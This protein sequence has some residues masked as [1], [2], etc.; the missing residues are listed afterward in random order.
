VEKCE[1]KAGKTTN[2]R[3]RGNGD[4]KKYWRGREIIRCLYPK[5]GG[6]SY[7]CS[8]NAAKPKGKGGAGEEIFISKGAATD[9]LKK[10]EV[11][12]KKSKK[13]YDRRNT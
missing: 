10:E 9:P 7:F 12:M 3:P 8:K 11:R 2:K 13:V 4:L 5:S 6:R 1:Q